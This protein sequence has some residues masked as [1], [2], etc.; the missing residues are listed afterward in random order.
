MDLDGLVFVAFVDPPV[1][2]L[3]VLS[4]R[5]VRRMYLLEFRSK[6]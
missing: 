2:F 1:L 4:V 5:Q 6:T 3:D